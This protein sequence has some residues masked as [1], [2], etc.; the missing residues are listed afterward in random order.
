M[1]PGSTSGNT[2][3]NL[4]SAITGGRQKPRFFLI[5]KKALHR[6]RLGRPIDDVEE[7]ILV[8]LFDGLVFHVVV[9]VSLA[10]SS[11]VAWVSC[12]AAIFARYH[13]N[14]R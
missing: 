14:A 2:W 7:A 1:S 8:R 6:E 10:L 4:V 12:G 11:D 5:R 13:G 3:S 9:V